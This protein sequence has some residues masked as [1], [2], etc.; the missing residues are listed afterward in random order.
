MGY[1]IFTHEIHSSYAARIDNFRSYDTV[2]KDILHRWTYPFVPDVQF[3]GN[4][5]I[6]KLDRRGMYR[7][8]GINLNQFYVCAFYKCTFIW[9]C[10][11]ADVGIIAALL[12][13]ILYIGS[14]GLCSNISLCIVNDIR[15]SWFNVIFIYHNLVI[16]YL[17]CTWMEG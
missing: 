13:I 3:S 6:I 11:V 9:Y 8:P 2:S 14:F 16:R 10:S 4:C 17:Q 15:L 5:P 1:K 7:A 12:S